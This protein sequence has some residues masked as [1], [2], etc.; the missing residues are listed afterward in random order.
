MKKTIVVIF[1]FAL[2]GWA[3][4]TTQG[5]KAAV[6]ALESQ[7]RTFMVAGG[8]ILN[9]NPVKGQ[10]YSAEAVNETT[11]TLADGNTI[12]NRSSTMIYRDSEGRERREESIGKIGTLNADGT[13]AKVVFI[14]DPVAK[15]SYALH[16]DD[17]TA[18]KMSAPMVVATAKAGIAVQDFRYSIRANGSA[19]PPGGADFLPNLCWA[20]RRRRRSARESREA[21]NPND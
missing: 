13:A 14:S 1:G 20:G 3:Q 17:R 8:Q 9:G 4:D 11:Q 6:D 18:E 12:V 5:Q 15:V 2:A 7:A 21:R 16:P 10:P 19:E